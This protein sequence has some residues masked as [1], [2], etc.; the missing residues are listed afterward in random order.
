MLRRQVLES[1]ASPKSHRGHARTLTRGLEASISRMRASLRLPAANRHEVCPAVQEPTVFVSMLTRWFNAT[2]LALAAAN[3]WTLLSA[4]PG[5]LPLL[6]ELLDA[7]HRIWSKNHIPTHRISFG[8][9]VA[10]YKDRDIL[11]SFCI[12]PVDPEQFAVATTR[13]IVEINAR[14]I[15]SKPA[16]QARLPRQQSATSLSLTSSNDQ[17]I[18]DPS[19]LDQTLSQSAR[20][21]IRDSFESGSQLKTLGESLDKSANR[22]K[23]K[24]GLLGTHTAE[25]KVPLVQWIECHPTQPVYVSGGIDGKV[26]VWSF[27]VP[28]PTT[29]Y[30]NLHGTRICKC[31]FNASGSRFGACDV[32]GMLTLWNFNN[33][34]PYFQ[35]QAH[36]KRTLD[37][38]FLNSGSVVASAGVSADFPRYVSFLPPGKTSASGTHCFRR[39]RRWCRAL[40]VKRAARPRLC[41]RPTIT[42]S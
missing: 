12:N 28:S 10:V 25:D 19:V 39:A 5:T 11:Q 6:A 29:T 34:S 3:L 4:E 9:E 16:S 7:E 26:Q 21:A 33:T 8:S 24:R 40:L 42:F 15:H 27:N 30:Q 14:A 20:Q 1:E 23:S 37:F 22:S 38:A 36:S 2:P 31:H 18:V 35:V 17:T 41:S 13:G 32:S